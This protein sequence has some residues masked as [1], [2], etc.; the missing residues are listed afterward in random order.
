MR[1]KFLSFW[2]AYS[3]EHPWLI[4]GIALIIAVFSMLGA[5]RL[6]MSMQWSD[7]L[8]THDPMVQEFDRIRKEYVG[9][10]NSIVVMIGKEDEMKAFADELA[11]KIEGISKYV[12]RVNYKI[13]EDFYRK[14]GLMLV[15]TKDL[16]SMRDN[17]VFSDFNLTGYLTHTNDNLE[18]VYVGDQES[19]SDKEK[20]DNAIR[21]LDG[22]QYWVTAMT[23]YLEDKALPDTLAKK[24]AEMLLI[25]DP[26]FLSYD[27]RML[28]MIVEPKFDITDV[29]SDVASTDSIQALI[30]NM[31]GKY[32]SVYA[33]LTGTIPLSRDEMVYSEKDMQLT[34]FVALGLVLLLF[35][36]SFRMLAAPV[37]AGVNLV[38]SVLFASGLISIFLSTL[39][40]MTSMF[41]VILIGLGIDFSIHII[42]LYYER[43]A[44]G[45]D[46]KQSMVIA[47]SR[48]GSGILT[49]ALTTSVAF[50][51]LMISQTKGIKEMGL[52]LGVGIMAVMVM[53]LFSLPALLVIRERLLTNV[54]KRPM[55]KPNPVEFIVISKAGGAIVK[56]PYV[57]L[58]ALIAVT[59]VMLIFA[60]NSKFDYNYL[61]MEPKGLPTVALQDSMLAAFELSPDFL[62]V[63]S[64]SLDSVRQITD[65]AKT[66][67]TVS[68]VESITNYLPSTTEQN[69][70][71]GII[72]V[73]RNQMKQADRNRPIT[74]GNLH[75]FTDQ[76]KRLDDNIY[77]IGQMAFLGGQ[78][79]VDA[80]CREISGNPDDS[81]SKSIILSLVDKI[82]NAP[83]KAIAALNIF[84]TPFRNDMLA[85]AERMADTTMIT[86]KDMPVDVR[87]RFINAAGDRYLVMIYPKKQVWD[88]KFLVRF[89]DQMKRLDEKITGTPPLMLRLIYLIGED[90]KISCLLALAVV[91][92]LLWL[93]FGSIK[94]AIIAMVPLIVG[95]VWMVGMLTIFGLKFTIVN[96]MALPMIIGIGIDD[97]VHL[98]HRYRIE[99]WD[100]TRAI[101]KSTGRAILLTS[102][103]TIA[104]FGSL[105]L[106]K[107]RGFGSLGSLLVMGVA[108]C[109]LTSILFLPTLV[110]IFRV[111]K[112]SS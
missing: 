74:A 57:S 81:S 12:A 48:S 94:E 6:K 109:F 107:Y 23:S 24:T 25:G 5:S 85:V 54:F 104:G 105:L 66:M 49:G 13:E 77:E 70:R 78:D 16:R 33:G 21:G 84:Q 29:E 102:L 56:R 80:K 106:A 37:L 9:T 87:E 69:Q 111:K 22:L 59:V 67:P 15:K 91:F 11:P 27:K 42:S 14:Y 36:F 76:L 58:I 95:A 46:I 26:Y 3:T 79:K 64:H 8:P 89:T 44:L 98:M 50:L 65:E 103:T 41:A 43:R 2:G 97:G 45:D 30:D 86:L 38:M 55:K 31:S 19:L 71:I 90:G 68:M 88:F 35:I 52:V 34:S 32:P 28:L 1:E 40:M 75:D 99:G 93:D 51:T 63:T 10:A 20:E 60:L 7:L 18:A 92:L 72:K 110:S 112:A 82:N 53:S 100:Q 96:V 83:D 4:A 101:L 62:M 73:L 17:Q 39:N 47:L 61:H 108:A